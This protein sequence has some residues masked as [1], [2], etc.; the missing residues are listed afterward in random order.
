M[1]FTFF[2]R[3]IYY[4]NDTAWFFIN[5]GIQPTG[6]Y[7]DEDTGISQPSKPPKSSNGPSTS[8]GMWFFWMSMNKIK[9]AQPILW[10]W[11]DMKDKG[12][13]NQSKASKYK[14]NF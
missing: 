12:G 6:K 7:V 2:F 1:I 4:G 3:L 14:D 8:S 11:I 10:V 9:T 13:W 5:R